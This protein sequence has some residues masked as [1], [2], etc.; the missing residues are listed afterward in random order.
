MLLYVTAVVLG[1]VALV[2]GADRFVDGAAAL[3]Q[4]LGVSPIIIGLTVVSFGTSLPELLVSVSATVMGHPDVAVGNVV[5]SNIAN[6]GLILG[7]ASLFRPLMVHGSLVHREYPLLIGVSV[8]A[9]LMARNGTFSRFEGLLLV[10]GLALFVA[11]MTVTAK[12]GAPEV[13]LKEASRAG[14]V[15]EEGPSSAK[16]VFSLLAG[17][18]GLTAGSRFLVW[19]G[20]AL[21]RTFGVSELVIGLTL[22]A[23]GTSL[24]ELATSVAGAI[25]KQDDIAVGNVV[26]SN[27]FN[28]LAILGI[29]SL[30]RPLQVSAEAF[31]RDFPVMLF[32]TLVLW[33]VCRSWRGR[34]GR[35]NRLEGGAL[36]AGYLVYVG[37]LLKP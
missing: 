3:A 31:H 14:G 21:A 28:T 32:A 9:W 10:A 12:Q 20:V 34:Q 25:K 18:I 4:R 17:L 15:F 37:I 5:G 1:T 7:A 13:L 26:G 6:I 8:L 22:V 2:W 24:P 36:V 23:L 16:L 27:L 29:P 19:G 35:V 30:I 33:P 11:W